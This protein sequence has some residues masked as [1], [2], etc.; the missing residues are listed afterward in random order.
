[1]RIGLKRLVIRQILT[2]H[3]GLQIYKHCSGDMLASSC[4]AEESVEGVVPS[5]D[6][7]ITGHLSIRLNPMLQTVKFPAGIANL[8]ASL[9]HMNGNTLAL[10]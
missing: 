6:R 5:T 7:L 8:D 9:T 2:Y 10:L 4:L 3:S 1:M